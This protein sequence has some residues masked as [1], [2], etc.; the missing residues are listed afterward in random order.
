MVLPS[1]VVKLMDF[2]IAR[3]EH[4]PDPAGEAGFLVGTPSYMSPE[5]AQGAGVDGRSDIY[6]IGAVLFEMFT[7]VTPFAAAD[8]M[9]VIHMHVASEPPAPSSLRPD[10]PEALERL[11]LACLAKSPVR[12][13]AAAQDLYGALMRMHLAEE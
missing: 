6:S 5:Q 10:L 13:P 2:G 12:R 7:G 1:G 4:G 3:T 9:A 11:I 8:P